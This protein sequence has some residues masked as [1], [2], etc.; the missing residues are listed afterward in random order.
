MSPGDIG[1]GVRAPAA[2]AALLL[3]PPAPSS[4]PPPPPPAPVPES[5]DVET[6]KSR[7]ELIVPGAGA[8]VC[9]LPVT[10]EF[11]VCVC[12]GKEGGPAGGT[13]GRR[14]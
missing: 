14:N 9:A 1:I 3:P 12:C 5:P 2:A 4:A 8:R 11:G 13:E 10:V 6:P 7:A